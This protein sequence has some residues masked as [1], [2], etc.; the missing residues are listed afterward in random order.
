MKKLLII[1]SLIIGC[2]GLALPVHAVL[3]NGKT[4]T[5]GYLYPDINTVYSGLSGNITV[6]PWLEFDASGTTFPVSTDISDNQIT[7]D[8]LAQGVWDNT[9]FNGYHI[10]DVYSDI[11]AFLSVTINPLTS[12]AGLDSS[13]IT[14]DDNYIWV[15]WAGL[16]FDSNTL[17][18]LDINANESTIPE[19][20][21]LLLLGA[22][23][24]G[25]AAL[26]MMRRV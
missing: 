15:N 4:V 18:V 3:L 14:F 9:S 1:A 7:N 5:L 24:A 11:D 2:S 23:L 25:V 10:F 26:R 21:T 22:G 20:S 17:V 6:G 13:R 12:M 16:A 8:Y 19:P